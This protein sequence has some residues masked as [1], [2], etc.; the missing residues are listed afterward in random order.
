MTTGRCLITGKPLDGDGPYSPEGLRKLDRRLATL[1]PLAFSREQLL[2]E[3]QVR[4]DRMSIQGVQPKLSAVLRPGEGRLDITDVKGRYILK[5][6]HPQWP[7]LPENEALTMSLAATVGLEVP[8]HGLLVG[9]DGARTYFVRRFDRVGRGKLSVEDFAQ[10][11]GASR[12]TKYDSSTEQLIGIIDRFCSFPLLDR[13]RLLERLLFAFMT[14]ND[15]MHLKNWSLITRDERVEFS[16]AYDLL[17]TAIILRS[18]EELALP[19]AGKKSNLRASDFW[20]YLARERLELEPGVI[21]EV[22]ARFA[23]ESSKWPQRVAASFLSPAMQER[24][25]GVLRERQ[26]RLF[27]GD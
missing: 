9:V 19:L 17:N 15:D 10:L 11:S 13:L 1:A 5:P 12:E 18:R 6:P 4:S 24:Y 25:L 14:G 7:E 3:A 26:A 2:E 20:D 8:L 21:K 23:A 16:P 27:H 22:K